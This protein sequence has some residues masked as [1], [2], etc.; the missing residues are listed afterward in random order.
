MENRLYLLDFR[1]SGVKYCKKKKYIYNKSS[2]VSLK[3]R[4]MNN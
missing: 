3:A 1:N 4:K 2:Y